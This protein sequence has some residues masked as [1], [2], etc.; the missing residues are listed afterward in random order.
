MQVATPEVIA[1]DPQPERVTSSAEK[2]TVPPGVP[3]EGTVALTVAVKMTDW[4]KTEGLGAEVS[5]VEVAACSMSWLMPDEVLVA[6][7][8]VPL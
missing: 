3:V 6:V 2:E 1:R 8:S 7:E 5:A 4:L